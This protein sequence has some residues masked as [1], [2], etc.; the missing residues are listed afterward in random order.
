M[1]PEARHQLIIGLLLGAICLA[2]LLYLSGLAA[3]L[4][5]GDSGVRGFL[6][7]PALPTP[8]YLT[9]LVVVLAAVGLSLLLSTLHR[10][11]R[12]RF[13]RAATGAGG[14]QALL[15]VDA[16]HAGVGGIYSRDPELVDPTWPAG[17]G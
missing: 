17:T 13:P 9:M 7:V 2:A 15:A 12:P 8:M 16:D 11:R 10:P 1:R 14:S 3:T 6:L 4:Q 5:L